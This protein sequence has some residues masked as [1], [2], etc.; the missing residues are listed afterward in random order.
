MKHTHFINPPFAILHTTCALT[1]VYYKHKSN[2]VKLFTQHKCQE[3]FSLY[4]IK[5]SAYKKM[6]HRKVQIL[7]TYITYF[8]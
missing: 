6:F 8:T 4:S 1:L 7:M 5:Y 3:F 2:V